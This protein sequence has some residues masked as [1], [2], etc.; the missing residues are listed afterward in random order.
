MKS[1]STDA[2]SG[3]PLHIGDR[4]RIEGHQ[5]SDRCSPLAKKPPKPWVTLGRRVVI[6]REKFLALFAD[7]T[8]DRDES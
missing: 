8:T 6:P 5:R 1:L 7:A 4:A 3:L 2:T